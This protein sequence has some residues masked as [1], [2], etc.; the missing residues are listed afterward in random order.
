M[1]VLHFILQSVNLPVNPFGWQDGIIVFTYLGPET[2]MPLAS[3]LA[4]IVGVILI[5]WRF[6]IGFIKRLIRFILRRPNPA[7]STVDQP[8]PAESSGEDP[9]I[10]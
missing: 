10:H 6:I 1:H 4:T 5:F 8:V 9:E 2:I 7:A 3:I